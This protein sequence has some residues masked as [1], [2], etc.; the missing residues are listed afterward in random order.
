MQSRSMK[1]VLKLP[2]VKEGELKS[3]CLDIICRDIQLFVYLTCGRQIFER[4]HHIPVYAVF[5]HHAGGLRC[6][7]GST[8]GNS[9]TGN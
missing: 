8:G 4:Y 5:S 7:A 3:G 6:L 1:P 2:D 9:G